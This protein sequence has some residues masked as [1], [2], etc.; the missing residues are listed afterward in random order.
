MKKESEYE[1][2][3]KEKCVWESDRDR[4]KTAIETAQ[5]NGNT[6]NDNVIQQEIDCCASLW[7]LFQNSQEVI[8][9]LLNVCRVYYG[10]AQ[11]YHIG[12]KLK[13]ARDRKKERERESEALIK[14]KKSGKKR[15]KN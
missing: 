11:N 9:V 7:Q 15:K 2:E 12:N 3:G 8:V 14:T 10:T 5:C 6:L 1:E 4:K 13:W